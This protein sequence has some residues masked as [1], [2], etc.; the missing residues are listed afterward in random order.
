MLAAL[1]KLGKS[2]TCRTIVFVIP[3]KMNGFEEKYLFSRFWFWRIIP[4]FQI[5][6]P[7]KTSPAA[8]R[9]SLGRAWNVCVLY[10]LARYESHIDSLC[11]FKRTI[12][13]LGSHPDKEDKEEE[14]NAC[15]QQYQLQPGGQAARLKYGVGVPMTLHVLH[16]VVHVTPLSILHIF[17]LFH[18]WKAHLV[19]RVERQKYHKV[20]IKTA[21]CM[22]LH[23]SGFSISMISNS[24]T[25]VP[26]FFSS[27][28]G[29]AEVQWWLHFLASSLSSF[30]RTLCLPNAAEPQS[31]GILHN[32]S[33][34]SCTE[35]VEIIS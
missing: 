18:L 11:S 22:L 4:L 32:N 27:W 15:C 5:W 2:H 7:K 26:S 6:T 1:L 25:V 9:G 10:I 13:L 35:W 34:K 21:C 19:T 23:S 14:K 16:V 12:G 24:S 31:T 29:A 20:I 8:D 28:L 17:R 3:H 30:L 33:V